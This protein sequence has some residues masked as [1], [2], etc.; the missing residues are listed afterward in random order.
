MSDYAASI[1]PNDY[2]E[3]KPVYVTN[4]TNQKKYNVPIKLNL[5]NTNFNFDTLRSDGGDFRLAAQNGTGVLNMWIAYWDYDS[6]RATVWFKLPEL[7][8]SET[9]T[10]WAFW[11]NASDTGISDI[12]SVSNTYNVT[13]GPNVAVSG[14]ATGSAVA[15]LSGGPSNVFDGDPDTYWW[16]NAP[17]WIKYDFG[18][19]NERQ[20][21]LMTLRQYDIKDFTIYGSNNDVTWQEIYS[22]QLPD[23]P[24]GYV[25]DVALWFSISFDNI[26]SYR[27]IKIEMTSW[28]DIILCQIEFYEIFSETVN[29]DGIFLFSEDFNLD[30]IDPSK[31]SSYG[32]YVISDSRIDLGTD[33]YIE[34]TDALNL[35]DSYY[36]TPEEE[37]TID[38][39][40][41]FYVQ[42]NYW[43][44]DITYFNDGNLYGTGL[45]LT[46]AYQA[47]YRAI[48]FALADSANNIKRIR[49][50]A[51]VPSLT[52]ITDWTAGSLN[53]RFSEELPS[54]YNTSDYYIPY[55]SMPA[56]TSKSGPY[57]T[58]DFVFD[59]PGK[60]A[61]KFVWMEALTTPYM[62]L[63]GGGQEGIEITEI[64]VYRA[65][66]RTTMLVPGW[67]V[68]EGIVGIGSPSSTGYYAHRYMFFGG[69]NE[70]ELRY[71][72]EGN[73]DRTH[74]FEY[75][76]ALVTYAGTNKG[77][78]IGSYSQNY[79]GYYE[80]TDFV[81]QGMLNRETSPDYGDTWERKVHRNTEIDKLR[82]YG[83]DHSTSNGVAIDWIIVREFDPNG[84]PEIDIDELLIP[85]ESIRHQ[86]LDFITYGTDITSV[87]FYH[88]SDI[89]GN[90]YL[91]SNN[92]VNSPLSIWSSSTTVSGNL[93]IDFGRRSNRINDDDYIHFD[94]NHVEFFAAVK[95]SDLDEDEYDSN[96]WQCTES[97]NVWAAIEY[98]VAK[99]VSCISVRAVPS[100][101]NGMIKDYKV[102][103]SNSDPR[104]T[105]ESTWTLIAEGTFSK[106][107]EEQ[108]IYPSAGKFYYYILKAENTYGDN[109]AVQEWAHYERHASLGKRAVAQLRLYPVVLS[110]QE[111]YFPKHIEFY[112]SNDGANWVQL[113]ENTETYTP[114]YDGVYGRWQRYSLSNNVPYY[115]YKLVVVDNWYAI[116]DI[117]RIAEWEMVER[118][119]EA[120]NHRILFGTTNDIAQIWADPAAT[121]DSGNIYALNDVL[122]TI[123]SNTAASY[124]TISGLIA[125]MNVIV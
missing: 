113:L 34:T 67:M 42:S 99:D 94:N 64:K 105:L 82:I 121:F 31:W 85:Y 38:E 36:T 114:F 100:K 77:L 58:F 63:D 9:K 21:E 59:P 122:N 53:L 102:Y 37:L 69:E 18:A 26:N 81:Y 10:L 51:K 28:S 22:G 2:R 72:W 32:S 84:D 107:E 76:G 50:Y 41:A 23:L 120:N 106:I 125:D 47:G 35:V 93:I 86:S 3:L 68:E 71:Y 117:I 49:V 87:D 39:G 45:I 52:D 7:R 56:L 66:A 108:T 16:F 25:P 123:Y 44:R 43:T 19:G 101:L 112:G 4:V 92:V 14:T 65:D 12:D 24:G 57:F 33:A 116:E 48:G 46:L 75:G 70:F 29:E 91:L 54:S 88:Y 8:A 110:N 124:T 40:I 89:G 30:D 103:G 20:V 61:D 60:V 74:N 104:L 96:Y 11:G 17:A 62:G 6:R 13:Y 98:P 55:A 78:E 5:N 119:T 80:D 111:Y 83:E 90:P 1:N 109:V 118:T 79:V 15:N 73:I 115:M 97:S 27:Y 95:L